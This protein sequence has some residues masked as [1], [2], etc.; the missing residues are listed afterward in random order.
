MENDAARRIT[1]LMPC[2]TS[3]LTLLRKKAPSTRSGVLRVKINIW[4]FS[5]FWL[6]KPLIEGACI[7]RDAVTQMGL[8]FRCVRPSGEVPDQG[9]VVTG[10]ICINGHVEDER[11]RIR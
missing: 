5:V 11:G 8:T 1:S 2:S 6:V 7:T 10:P 3:K 9:W 4:S